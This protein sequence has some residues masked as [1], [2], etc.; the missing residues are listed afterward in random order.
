MHRETIEFANPDGHKLSGILHHAVGDP[1]AL[2]V[3]AHCFTCT[4]RSKAAVTICRELARLGI[5][6]LRFDFT[7]LGESEG[8][9]SATNFTTNLGDIAAAAAA[10]EQH[11][12]MPVELLVG[13][14]LGGTAVLSAATDLPQVRAVA[15]LGAPAN[16]EHIARLVHASTVAEHPDALEVQ[17]GG[18]PFKVGRQLFEDF[19][20]HSMPERLSRL[21]AAV[22]VMHAPLDAIVEIENASEIFL[23]AKHPKSF[24][25]LD[26]ADHL[27]SGEG[28]AEYA[29]RVIAA[30][31]RRY[32]T[33]KDRLEPSADAAPG[34]D[35]VA[36]THGGS[37]LTSLDVGGHALIA[38]EPAGVGGENLGPT[39]TRLLAAALAACTSMTL[40]MYARHKG[41]SVDRVA[42]RVSISKETQPTPTADETV[43]V[44][45]RTIELVGELDD[46]Q[47]RRLIEIAERCPVHRTLTGQVR[48][49]TREA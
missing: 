48:I 39:P 3:F 19:G 12:A 38:D 24:V 35:A 6:T 37:F 34:A 30:W 42:T 33:K 13:H 14:S 20:A 15:T 26:T 17:I 10:L 46:A 43:N 36:T 2:A 23:G 16:P 41:L 29:A 18:Q 31:S 21:R 25:S 32:L 28:E 7:G 40:Q 8:E 22:L 49:D 1:R 11:F 47:H 4:A 27:L 5:A 44:F 45:D 9:F